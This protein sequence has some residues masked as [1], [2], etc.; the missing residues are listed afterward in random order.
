VPK[1]DSGRTWIDFLNPVVGCSITD[2][3]HSSSGKPWRP[4]AYL[5]EEG[6]VQDLDLRTAAKGQFFEAME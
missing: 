6:V 5:T 3:I 4:P 2:T 1:G